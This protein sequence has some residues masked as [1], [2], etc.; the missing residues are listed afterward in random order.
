[1]KDQEKLK[2]IRDYVESISSQSIEIIKND[3]FEDLEERNIA[4]GTLSVS[5]SVLT[6]LNS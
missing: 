4:E 6:I 1:M 5:Q 2:K 3:S